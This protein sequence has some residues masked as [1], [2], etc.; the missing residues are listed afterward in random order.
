MMVLEDMAE[1]VLIVR[2]KRI[3]D[4]PNFPLGLRLWGQI[5][6]PHFS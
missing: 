5:R 3:G 4:W 1:E 2:V 6:L